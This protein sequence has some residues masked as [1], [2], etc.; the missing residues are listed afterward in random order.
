MPLRF[1]RFAALILAWCAPVTGAAWAGPATDALRAFLDQNYTAL[2][3][4][5]PDQTLATP[6]ALKDSLTQA[7]KERS[8]EDW[9]RMGSVF[10]EGPWRDRAAVIAGKL[11]Q[12][13]GWP[14]RPV[15]VSDYLAPQVAIF[16]NKLVISRIAL[17]LA[18]NDSEVAAMMLPV[19]A[20]YAGMDQTALINWSNARTGWRALPAKAD[21]D[22]IRDAV[23]DAAA[24]LWGVQIDGRGKRIARHADALARAGY[25]PDAARTA[26][27]IVSHW[28]R[29]QYARG[30]GHPDFA[31]YRPP[32]AEEA[33]R[34]P[35]DPDYLA[36][37][38][39]MPLGPSERGSLL[40]GNQLLIPRWKV[41]LILPRDYNWRP[42]AHGASAQ[43][44]WQSEAVTIEPYNPQGEPRTAPFFNDLPEYMRPAGPTLTA[45]NDRKR[46]MRFTFAPGRTGGRADRPEIIA[47]SA[48]WDPYGGFFVTQS[49]LDNE[50]PRRRQELMESLEDRIDDLEPEDWAAL[51]PRV[52]TLE[53]PRSKAAAERLLAE[54]TPAE[55]HMVRVLNG[56]S[57][58]ERLPVGQPLKVPQQVPDTFMTS[59]KTFLS[60]V[61][62]GL[63]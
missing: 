17:A 16:G 10:L 6:P 54:L 19:L 2:A 29:L 23:D 15:V 61:R 25:D 14:C 1:P 45:V 39:D 12:T 27:L 50:A 49:G 33:P 52:L 62:K 13:H 30:V 59:F 32:A 56:L 11:C 9:H 41:K 5:Y 18:R 4:E 24:L 7:L 8:D 26:D 28:D 38:E 36:Q 53:T 22:A 46:P 63:E 55:E 57:A 34:R 48:H 44:D 60:S 40:L 51:K 42:Y 21:Q 35:A 20:T 43:A 47:Y 31:P 37:L 3:A 58:T